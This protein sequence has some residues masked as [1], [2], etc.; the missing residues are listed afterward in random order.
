MRNLTYSLETLT[1]GTQVA[2]AYCGKC[3]G[4]GYLPGYEFIDNARC[5]GCMGHKG[6]LGE[7]TVAEFTKREARNAKARARRQAKRQEAAEARRAERDAEFTA[8]QGEHTELLAL[9]DGYT[10]VNEFVLDVK[11]CVRTG[12]EVSERRV[13]V[14]VRIMRESLAAQPV[15]A[16]RQQVTGTIRSIK[17]VENNYGGTTKMLVDCGSFRVY[18]TLPAGLDCAEVGDTVTFTATLEPGREVGFGFFSRPTVKK[19]AVAA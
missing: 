7:I 9:L 8:W 14:A 13:E 19:V 17:W 18:G 3:G 2:R 10:G 1:D 12:Y 11:D 15:P 4:N 16:G 5:W 6:S